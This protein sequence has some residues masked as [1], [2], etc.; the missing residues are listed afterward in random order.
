M[1]HIVVPQPPCVDNFKILSPGLVG[2]IG[3]VNMATRMRTSNAAMFPVMFSKDAARLPRLGSELQDGDTLAQVNGGG[4]PATTLAYKWNV[5]QS[6][7]TDVGD[8]WQDLRQNDRY[9]EPI[10]VGQNQYDFK[11]IVAQIEKAKVSGNQF[12]PLPNGYGELTGNPR[13]GLLPSIVATE[14]IDSVTEGPQRDKFGRILAPL[15][16]GSSGM[17]SND[18]AFKPVLEPL[19][20]TEPLKTPMGSRRPSLMASSPSSSWRTSLSSMS[21][22]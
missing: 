17:V 10:V 4:Y 7:K 3:D 2:S 1:N 22:N 5:K 21:T 13:G 11:N 6:T 12:L 15:S 16:F 8:R 14:G 19:Y 20:P 18:S 9:V